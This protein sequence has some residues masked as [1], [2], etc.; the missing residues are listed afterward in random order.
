MGRHMK[1]LGELKTL[2][3]GLPETGIMFTNDLEESVKKTR[4]RK[5]LELTVHAS[6][7]SWLARPM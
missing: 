2:I 7:I 1:D 5:M 6:D 4:K 3:E